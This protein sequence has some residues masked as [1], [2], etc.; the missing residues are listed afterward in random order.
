[1]VSGMGPWTGRDNH[2]KK[3]ALFAFRGEEMC[4]VHVLLNALDFHNS[5]FQAQIILEG[6]SVGLVGRM[7]EDGPLKAL[8]ARCREAGLVAGV[9][10]ACAKKL[11]SHDACEEQGLPLLSG[12]NGH[13]GMAPFADSGYQIT[14]F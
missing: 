8:F 4:F 11:G 13:A 7:G 9:C 2:V 10:L 6:E 5:G 14:T 3:I 1:M 12:M